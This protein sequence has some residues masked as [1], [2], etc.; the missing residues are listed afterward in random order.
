MVTLHVN[1]AR[2][3]HPVVWSNVGGAATLKICVCVCLF[4]LK[5]N[6]HLNQ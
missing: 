4:V 3:W 6:S 5:Y 2:P 1:L